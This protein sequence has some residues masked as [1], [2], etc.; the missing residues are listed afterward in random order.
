MESKKYKG[1]LEVILGKH[2]F[3]ATTVDLEF[4]EPLKVEAAIV[5]HT[6]KKPL[7]EEAE[8]LDESFEKQQQEEDDNVTVQAAVDS[9]IIKP[10]PKP[11]KPVIK[12]EAKPKPVPKKRKPQPPKKLVTYKE[13]S[14]KEKAVVNTVFLAECKKHGIDRPRLQLKEGTDH[15]KQ[16]LRKLVAKATKQVA[17]RRKPS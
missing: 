1:A 2:Y 8:K 11:K 10:K 4:V 12:E 3:V 6:N 9:V 5:A 16:V 17:L 7:N 15:T 13:M 14:A